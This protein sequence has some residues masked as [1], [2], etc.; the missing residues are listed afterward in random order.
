MKKS[1]LTL[2]A[3]MGATQMFSSSTTTTTAAPATGTS[4]NA[5]P[6]AGQATGTS[7]TT[8]VQAVSQ[9]KFNLLLEQ[10]IRTVATNE[11]VDDVTEQKAKQAG[12]NAYHATKVDSWGQLTTAQ[13]NT[14]GEAI[15]K[16][17]TSKF[18]AK[19]GTGPAA[20]TQQAQIIINAKKANKLIALAQCIEPSWVEEN[21]GTTL[22]GASLAGLGGYVSLCH[23]DKVDASKVWTKL[24]YVGA[25]FSAFKYRKQINNVCKNGWNKLRKL[26]LKNVTEYIPTMAVLG[27]VLA[28]QRYIAK[29]NYD[30]D[31]V[32]GS[33]ANALGVAPQT[34]QQ[35]WLSNTGNTNPDQYSW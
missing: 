18:T 13:L 29:Q 4:A 17:A 10:A 34:W 32:V 25:L 33:A 31:K 5:A 16:E 35:R 19:I 30:M 11:S 26:N 7:A 22:L 23:S 3:L 6:T 21:P 12:L 24:G 8:S 28:T 2:I 15:L 9:T 20:V 1:L 14:I 27:G